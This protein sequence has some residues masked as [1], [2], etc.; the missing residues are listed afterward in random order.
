MLSILNFP[1]LTS[2]SNASI[3]LAIYMLL[4]HFITKIQQIKINIMVC[5]SPQLLLKR[6]VGLMS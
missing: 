3:P 6:E 4:S 1:V 2:H 5:L